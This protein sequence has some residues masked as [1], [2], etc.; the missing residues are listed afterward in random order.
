MAK[1][2]RV[3]SQIK[4]LNSAASRELA[5]PPIIINSSSPAYFYLTAVSNFSSL[6]QFSRCSI[7]RVSFSFP[8]R[9]GRQFLAANF[10]RTVHS[11]VY[12]HCPGE[13][14]DMSSES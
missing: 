3:K 8:K 12:A 6:S 9:R 2:H 10:S 1:G 11:C 7:F 14:F 4:I 5:R 13:L